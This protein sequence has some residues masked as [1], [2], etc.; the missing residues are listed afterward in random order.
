MTFF[1]IKDKLSTNAIE[2]CEHFNEFFINVWPTLSENIPLQDSGASD[3]I[4]KLEHTLYLFPIDIQ[5][6]ETIIK[7]L[8][9]SSAGWDDVSLMDKLISALKEGRF[10]LGLFFISRKHSIP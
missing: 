8:N 1:K 7:N 10:V 2:M 6:M 5:E 9:N 3:F 4:E